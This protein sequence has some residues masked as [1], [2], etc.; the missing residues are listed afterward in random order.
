V[1]VEVV[2]QDSPVSA[3]VTSVSENERGDFEHGVRV[4]WRGAQT[5]RLDDTRFTG[6]MIT[7]RLSSTSTN[8]TG[9]M[10]MVGRGCDASWDAES[11]LISFACTADLQLILLEP[12]QSHD[13]PVRIPKKIGPLVVLEPGTYV[14]DQTIHWWLQEGIDA[15]PTAEGEFTIR[16]RYEVQ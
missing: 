5:A 15:Q 7:G 3:E 9:K 10:I 2:D 4:T 6:E 1:Q 14:F 8:D 11:E 16:L 13:Y 12:G